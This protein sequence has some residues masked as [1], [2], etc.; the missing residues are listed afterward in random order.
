MSSTQSS[1]SATKLMHRS[2][3]EQLQCPGDCDK[4]DV[5]MRAVCVAMLLT[6]NT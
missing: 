3:K 1:F 6:A 2:K 4:R 5:T